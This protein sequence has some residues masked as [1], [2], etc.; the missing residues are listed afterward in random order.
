MGYPRTA[1]RGLATL[2]A[3]LLVGGCVPPVLGSDDPPPPPVGTGTLTEEQV[4]S[5]LPQVEQAPEGFHLDPEEEDSA[6]E[7]GD[8]AT[9]YPAS[10]LDIRLAG[11]AGKALKP[12]RKARLKRSFA[13]DNGGS[14]TV[15]ITS[16]DQAV[17]AQLFDDAGAAQSQCGTFQLIDETG[18]SSWKLARV[19]F[20]Q[21]GDRT[22][23]ARVESTTEGDIFQGGVVQI[24][25][26]SRGNNLVYVVYASGPQ[27]EYDPAA[28]ETFTTA[29]INNLDAL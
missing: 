21:I 3:L 29:T 4:R 28:V 24:A 15:T 23:S 2:T 12:H 18:T 11:T 5:A 26:A 6:P 7:P 19:A 13:G 8:E 22:Y 27:S 14:L 1:V 16:H 17:P 25:G 9:A 20:P 10:C